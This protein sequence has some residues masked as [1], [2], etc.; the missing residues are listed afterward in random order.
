MLDLGV[1]FFYYMG[2]PILMLYIF[3]LSFTALISI[4]SFYILKSLLTRKVLNLTPLT[5]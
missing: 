2:L 4:A 3:G 5:V 1:I